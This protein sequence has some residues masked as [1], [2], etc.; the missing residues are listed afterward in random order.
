MNNDMFWQMLQQEPVWMLL[1]Q[2]AVV[3]AIVCIGI[4]LPLITL[5]LYW[6]S[7]TRYFHEKPRYSPYAGKEKYLGH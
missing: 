6:K 7:I 3:W 5:K 2:I 4:C 1:I